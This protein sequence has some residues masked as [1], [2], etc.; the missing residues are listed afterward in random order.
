MTDRLSQILKKLNL[1]ASQ[2]A[3]E[4]GVQRSSISHVLSGRNKPS[5]DFITKII[6]SYPEISAEW[7]L[8]GS[9]SMLTRER[10]GELNTGSDG[11]IL[12]E[13][14]ENIPQR[15]IE[16]PQDMP[17][18]PSAVKKKEAGRAVIRSGSSNIEK[19]VFFYT[20]G[21]FEEYSPKG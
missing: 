10:M 14:G 15:N 8:T 4:I 11:E 16:I 3:D 17:T 1:T 7:L 19:I 12:E 9:G 5:L 21:S 20:D 18:A 13:G 6:L 2:F